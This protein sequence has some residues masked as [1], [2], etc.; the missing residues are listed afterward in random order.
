VVCIG[1]PT[2]GDLESGLRC[3][4]EAGISTLHAGPASAGL[5]FV[6]GAEAAEEA[7]RALHAGLLSPAGEAVA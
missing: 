6:V 5:V 4:R 2:E 3:L 1:V 7:L